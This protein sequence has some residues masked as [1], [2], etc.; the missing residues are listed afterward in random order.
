MDDKRGHFLHITAETPGEPASVIPKATATATAVDVATTAPPPDTEFMDGDAFLYVRGNDI[1]MCTTGMRVGGME[2][3]LKALFSAAK[4]R[5]DANQFEIMN[6]LDAHKI[7][8]L[9]RGGVR[10]IEM[11]GTLFRASVDY[12]K[13]KGQTVSAMDVVAKHFRALFGKENDVTEDSLRVMVTLKIDK[14][15]H[16]IAIG[17][18]RLEELA[19]NLVENQQ[20]EDEYTI[21]TERN[22]QIKPKDILL[23]ISA[24]IDSVGKSVDR[25]HAWAAPLQ[26]FEE[27]KSEGA[28]ET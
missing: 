3:F 17:H 18:K 5:R 25:D 4:I 11:R 27:L 24:D 28:F 1:C 16:G 19:T 14:R 23:R 2:Y 10:E 20:D 6:A 12:G 13:R 9:Q 8:I 7:E 22:E 26:Y 21:I 15:R